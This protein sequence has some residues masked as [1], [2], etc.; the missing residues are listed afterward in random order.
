MRECVEEELFK[1][2]ALF[3]SANGLASCVPREFACLQF[4]KSAD[5]KQVNCDV[6]AVEREAAI[7]VRH[8]AVVFR[9]VAVF[10]DTRLLVLEGENADFFVRTGLVHDLGSAEHV[11]FFGERSDKRRVANAAE[12]VIDAVEEHVLHAAFHKPC[13]RSALGQCTEATAVSVRNE[14]QMVFSVADSLSVGG[15]CADGTLFK[16]PDVFAV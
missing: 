3:D 4:A 11:A 1:L 7:G 13:Q 8:V 6:A 16:E 15:K 10:D 2:E 5:F 12:G 9:K 14:R